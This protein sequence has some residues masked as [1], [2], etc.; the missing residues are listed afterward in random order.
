MESP[1][2]YATPRKRR[3]GFA[4]Y[5]LVGLNCMTL[6]GGLFLAHLFHQAMADHNGW[7]Q[8]G[9][10]IIGTPLTVFQ[11]V[12]CIVSAAV[13]ER[14]RD[15]LPWFAGLSL[16]LNAGVLLLNALGPQYGGC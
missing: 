7:G 14:W 5:L 4:Y 16:L 13:V 1:L 10:I 8:F 15:P 11:A 9:V 2:D 6:L 3:R 12:I